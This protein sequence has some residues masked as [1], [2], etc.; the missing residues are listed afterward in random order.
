MKLTSKPTG[1]ASLNGFMFS[2]SIIGVVQFGTM[3]INLFIG[4]FVARILGIE[5]YGKFSYFVSL[6]SLVALLISFGF[7][8]EATRRV[9]SNDLHMSDYSELTFAR[10]V[11]VFIS[12]VC[13]F[14]IYLYFRDFTYILA[15]LSGA[16]YALYQYYIGGFSGLRKVWPLT[17]LIV[18]QPVI[19][20]GLLMMIAVDGADKVALLLVASQFCSLIIAIVLSIVYKE[21]RIKVRSINLLR[22]IRMARNLIANYIITILQVSYPLIGISTLGIVK[23][24][25]GAGSLNIANSLV[26]FLPVIMGTLS[27]SVFY[28]RICADVAK[29]NS[30]GVMNTVKLFFFVGS[31]VSVGCAVVSAVFADDIVI[32]VYTIKY[33]DASLLVSLLSPLCFF[34]F[35]D[36]LFTWLLIGIERQKEAIYSQL[37]RS[38][39]MIFVII[40]SSLYFTELR[41]YHIVVAY[42]ISSAIGYIVQS[43][44]VYKL[45]NYKLSHWPIIGS[46]LAAFVLCVVARLTPSAIATARLDMALRVSSVVLLY[47]IGGLL[48]IRKKL[49]SQPVNISNKGGS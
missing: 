5:E 34:G 8:R 14:I 26:G 2:M 40:M 25:T 10:Y 1:L 22:I 39:S 48:I 28:P 3:I 17:L 32:L 49:I 45:R 35:A 29:K 6:F 11:S 38:S 12:V 31:I 7:A 23:D 30:I 20:G 47:G 24:Y 15:T 18:A 37:I 44:Y 16:I 43:W 42:I 41:A 13:G 27:Y 36:H 46:A 4:L 19:Y 9:V 21:M 33:V